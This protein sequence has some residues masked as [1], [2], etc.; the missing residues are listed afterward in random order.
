MGIEIDSFGGDVVIK[1]DPKAETA[2]I[3]ATRWGTHGY[4]RRDESEASLD[5]IT[6]SYAVEDRPE[7]K[8]IVV[9]ATS[10]APEPWFQHVDL[11]V[12]VPRLGAAIVRSSRGHV[13]VTDFTDGVDIETTKGDVRAVSNH[14]LS[15]PSTILNAEGSINW[16][17]PAGSAAM[18]EAEA[19]NGTVRVRVRD[20]KWLAVDSRNDHDSMYGSINQ[21]KNLVIL[22][23]VDGDVRV[24]VG[25]NPTQTGS[26]GE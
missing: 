19:V 10:T 3:E 17:A 18:I 22:R 5:S 12:I 11:V 4:G 24:F 2:S 23:T 14:V 8:T 13:Y 6:V 16:R 15:H 25:P 20:G 26:F 1:A 9:K 7:G 21:G